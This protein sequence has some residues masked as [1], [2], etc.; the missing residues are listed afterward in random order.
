MG[1][2]ASAPASSARRSPVEQGLRQ[3]ISSCA[4]RYRNPVDLDVPELHRSGLIYHVTP[5]DVGE[6]AVDES[7]PGDDT[8]LEAPDI[9]AEF[10]APARHVEHLDVADHGREASLGSF[11]I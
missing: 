8:A 9:N 2:W 7:Y 6:V 1:G 10:T 3:A 5:G 11:L 4:S